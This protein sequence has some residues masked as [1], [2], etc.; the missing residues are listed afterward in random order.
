ML[1]Q[2]KFPSTLQPI[3]ILSTHARRTHP[4]PPHYSL[5]TY[6]LASPS[7]PLLLDSMENKKSIHSILLFLSPHLT[8]VYSTA[9][10]ARKR[11]TESWEGKQQNSCGQIPR[12]PT[13]NYSIPGQL[14][15]SQLC[16]APNS[17]L[18]SPRIPFRMAIKARFSLWKSTLKCI[19][20]DPRHPLAGIVTTPT[21]ATTI[22]IMCWTIRG[23]G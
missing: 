18:N 22:T 14:P 11:E 17:A 9:A 23:G 5:L 8:L 15:H 6:F 21:I 4:P 20:L 1:I 2:T 3:H 19:V 7:P 12:D 13:G 16:S 10:A